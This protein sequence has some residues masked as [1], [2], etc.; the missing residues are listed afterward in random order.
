[1]HDFENLEWDDPNIDSFSY[2]RMSIAES[3]Y[4]SYCS[5]YELVFKRAERLVLVYVAAIGVL[6]TQVSALVTSFHGELCSMRLLTLVCTLGYVAGAILSLSAY[7]P[8]RVEPPQDPKYF[9][10]NLLRHEGIRDGSV[11]ANMT[12]SF[13]RASNS[14]L[15]VHKKKDRLNM[16]AIIMLFVFGF[17]LLLLVLLNHTD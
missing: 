17:S 3:V 5:D 10:N 15:E 8:M 12:L 9:W 11:R 4:K 6:M 16:W 2:E 1:M 7:L 14:I 13:M